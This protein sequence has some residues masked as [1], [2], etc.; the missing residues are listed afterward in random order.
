MLDP[1][2]IGVHL[3]GKLTGW[4]SPKDV[5]TYLCGLL[6]VKGGTN[7]IIE[8]FGPG[9]ESISATGKG[10][11]CNMGAELGATTS[12]FHFDDRMA[13]YLRATD[14]A[15]IARLAEQ[16]RQHLV[17]D[18]EVIRDPR[19]FYDEIVEINLS[20][21][22]PHIV[23]PHSPDRARPI[24]QAGRRGE[25]GR[26]ARGDPPGPDRLLHQLLVRGHA[27]GRPHRDAGAQGRASRPRP[28]SW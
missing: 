21:L 11:I 19:K 1:K 28:R 13:A 9:A 24:S 18:P 8:Y 16:H 2:L 25:E 15:D 7:K 23:G 17:A 4:S 27:A 26:L 6:T 3:T 22:E 14:R 5:I 20:E 12:L 10:T